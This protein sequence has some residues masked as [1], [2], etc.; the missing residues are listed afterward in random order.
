MDWSQL[1][2]DMRD[3]KWTQK[4]LADHCG[5]SQSTIS[6]LA[7]GDTT[8]PTYALGDALRQLHASNAVPAEVAA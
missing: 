8:S 1:L 2:N 4:L 3:R 7:T 6:A 5:V